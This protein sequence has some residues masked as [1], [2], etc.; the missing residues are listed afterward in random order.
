M[1]EQEVQ[2]W[3]DRW[4]AVNDFQEAEQRASTME[5][6]WREANG[7]RLLAVELAL[8]LDTRDAEAEAVSRRWV[9]LHHLGTLGAG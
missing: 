1:T 7:L 2:A 8:P 5:Q 6:R 3:R 4:K 9:R